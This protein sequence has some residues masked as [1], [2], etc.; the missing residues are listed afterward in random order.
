MLA[1]LVSAGV[2][3]WQGSENRAS[4][5]RIAREQMA[6]Q[7][8]FAQMGI[9]WKVADAQ[10]AGIHPLAA[11]GASTTSYSPVSVGDRGG[12][13]FSQMGQDLGRAAKAAM[14]LFERKNEDEEK[15]R[16]LELENRELQ[17]DVLRADLASRLRRES[18]AGGQLGPNMPAPA[19]VMPSSWLRMVS[20]GPLP[21]TIS[22]GEAVKDDDIKQKA[23]DF[24]ATKIV[25]PFGY[26]LEANPWFN[27]GQQ[28][29]DRYGDSEI[30]STVKFGVNTLADH[31][32]TAYR[33]WPSDWIGSQLRGRGRRYS[34][35]RSRAYGE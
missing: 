6:A 5:E 2:N 23:E 14:S 22:E 12:E 19:G 18:R 11:L 35:S 24:P 32:Y 21:R 16:K 29:E 1:D 4:S 31:L 9:R 13:Q 7:K 26:P 8:E 3:A 15:G 27:D 10:A 33:R 34:R 25:R 30:G 28:F 17:N 20:G